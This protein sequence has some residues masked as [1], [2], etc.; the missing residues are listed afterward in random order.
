VVATRR[1]YHFRQLEAHYYE[2]SEV[3]VTGPITFGDAVPVLHN[4]RTSAYI[5][6]TELVRSS[7]T[8]VCVRKTKVG[9]VIVKSKA[10]QRMAAYF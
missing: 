2:A 5:L 6:R 10:F 4:R 3:E 7:N 1:S 9:A 8:I